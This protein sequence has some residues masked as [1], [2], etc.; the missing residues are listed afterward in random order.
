MKEILVV[1]GAG[2]IGSHM[3][4]YL[5]RHGMQPVVLDN[6]SQGHRQAVKWGLL[7]EGNMDDSQLLQEIFSN[8]SIEAVMHFAALCYVGESMHEP[9]KYYQNNISSTL[10]LVGSMLE[11]GVTRLIFSSTCATYGEPQFLPITEDHPQLPINPYGRS[12]L[13]M[14]QI[15]DDLD[16]ASGLKSVC[17]RY[18][19]AAGADPEGELGEDHRPETH[20][21]P[22][23][24][25]TALGKRQELTVFG[26]DYPTADGTCVRDYIH[27]QDL[28]QAHY[29]CLQYLLDGKPSKKF[30]LGNGN[31]YSIGQVIQTAAEVTGRQLSYKYAQRRPGDP[32]TLVGSSERISKELGWIPEFNTLDTIM[33]TAWNWHVHNPEGFTAS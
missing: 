17:L 30:N 2:Y 28:A 11:H 8:H 22:L 12:K 10:G 15:L 1:G 27:I 33:Q 31:G 14:E 7:Y 13:M 9:L 26:D 32:A 16:S 29:L 20:L 4:K 6:L 5:H 25:E 24:L 21:I 3:C 19:N 18:F 23:I